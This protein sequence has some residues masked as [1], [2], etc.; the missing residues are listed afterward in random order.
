MIKN[1]K[2]KRLLGLILFFCLLLYLASGLY[3]IYR[4]QDKL[5]AKP[6]YIIVMGSIVEDNRPGPDLEKRIDRTLAYA[7]ENNYK[8]IIASGYSYGEN[9]SEG[10]II[11]EE[12][13]KNGLDPSSI[14]VEDQARNTYENLKNSFEVI[15]QLEEDGDIL[16]ISSNY[17]MARIK[18]LSTRLDRSIYTLGARTPLK[19]II[20]SYSREVLALYKSLIFDRA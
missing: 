10:L 18:L 4:S 13:V 14:M 1:K 8:K 2:I 3:L 17:H 20:F 7:K 6:A 11:K 9:K 12:L 16:I 5:P 19:R 15:D